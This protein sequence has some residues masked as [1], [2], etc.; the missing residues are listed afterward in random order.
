MSED[1]EFDAT[2]PLFMPPDRRNAISESNSVIEEA[3][4][5]GNPV[6]VYIHGRAKNIG[7][8]KKSVESNIYRGLK[9][10]GIS[11]IGFT[12]DADDSV[13]DETRPIASA[14]DFVTFL[15]ALGHYLKN[16]PNEKKPTLLAH[17]M[18]NII[19]SELA[20]EDQ[21][22]REKG[23]LF[24]NILLSAAAVKTKRH[25]KWLKKIEVSER[26]YVLV[27]PDDKVLKFAG[28]LF[29]PDMLGRELRGPGVSPE[30]AQYIDLRRLEVNHRYF[31]PAG[32][33]SQSNLKTFF[34][35]ALA[36][37]AVDLDAI[38]D[39]ERVEGVSVYTIR[40]G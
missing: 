32:Q 5:T 2:R 4:A 20:K 37:K 6:V 29:K 3:Y 34:A 39:I 27:N 1:L 21:L 40:P 24:K 36:G 14:E 13:Y 38:A 30:N 16:H 19:V 15:M 31:V 8:P 11:V 22:R 28:L 26:L 10:Y 35:E 25:H 18:G 17:S 23:D 7:E 33:K 9:S 12:W